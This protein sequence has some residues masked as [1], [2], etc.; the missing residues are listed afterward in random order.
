[1]SVTLDTSQSL[2][3]VRSVSL[4]QP[5]NMLLMLVTLDTSHDARGIRAVRLKQM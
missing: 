4:E 2:R 5:E 1:M 3:P